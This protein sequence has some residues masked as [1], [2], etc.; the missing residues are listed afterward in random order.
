MGWLDDITQWFSDTF[1][2]IWQAF[3]DF[4]K[5][6]IVFLLDG[7]L[8]LASLAINAIPAPDF[9]HNYSLSAILGSA[10]PTV[11]W[12]VQTFQIGPALGV[13]G[14]AYAFRMMRK[15]LTLFQW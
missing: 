10:G 5:D 7:V 12:V 14:A 6:F 1:H 4:L 8:S 13:I 2:A 15:V 9:L 3:V 11:N